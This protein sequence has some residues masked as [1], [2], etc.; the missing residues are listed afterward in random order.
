M[1]YTD[2]QKKNRQLVYNHRKDPKKFPDVPPKM[3]SQDAI[4]EYC[5]DYMH[6]KKAIAA[7]KDDY[8]PY[9]APNL[10]HAKMLRDEIFGDRTAQ[11][12]KENLFQ[13]TKKRLD[14]H[15]MY[16]APSCCSTINVRTSTRQVSVYLKTP[17]NK[18]MHL[19]DMKPNA[20]DNIKKQKDWTLDDM[21]VMDVSAKINMS[22]DEFKEF[23]KTYGRSTKPKSILHQ[24]TSWKK[25]KFFANLPLDNDEIMALEE[26]LTIITP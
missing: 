7:R 10:R 6:R 4:D 11:W 16:T 22:W 8:I 1:N 26:G 2:E 19:M 20:S 12:G 21:K 25:Y 24:G 9:V 15:E 5:Y 13:I 14:R 23:T 18:V 3:S 17:D